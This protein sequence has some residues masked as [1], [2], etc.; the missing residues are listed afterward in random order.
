MMS[1]VHCDCTLFSPK[2]NSIK[3]PNIQNRVPN[4]G[5]TAQKHRDN[6]SSKQGYH[7]QGEKQR[8]RGRQLDHGNWCFL[9]NKLSQPSW[10]TLSHIRLKLDIRHYTF[11]YLYS[12]S[13]A[14][15][16]F[17]KN[18]PSHLVSHKLSQSGHCK[19]V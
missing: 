17:E 2:T 18:V 19:S 12:S 16:R 13:V 4:R 10:S 3:I 7:Y 9:I 5:N 14:F 1:Y 8:R 6:K 15:G 11:S